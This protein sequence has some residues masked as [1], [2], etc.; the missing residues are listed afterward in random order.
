MLSLCELRSKDVIKIIKY[1][2]DHIKQNHSCVY[3]GSDFC[4]RKLMTISFD[5]VKRIIEYIHQ[6]DSKLFFVFPIVPERELSHFIESVHYLNGIEIDGIV[7]NDYGALYY[8]SNKYSHIPLAIGRLLIKNARDYSQNI[9]IQ[10]HRCPYEIVRI[11]NLYQIHQI[12]LD[13]DLKT[14]QLAEEKLLVHQ[15]TYITSAMRCEYKKTECYTS[16]TVNGECNFECQKQVI[17]IGDGHAYR[18]GNAV[19]CYN[20]NDIPIV[21]DYGI[22]FLIKQHQHEDNG[23]AKSSV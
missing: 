11:A 15:Y 12:H 10:E 9:N 7:V 4:Y 17:N 18:I 3:I 23:T 19:I 13:I 20:N 16:Y 21:L 8:I 22:D 1:L 2:I 14:E 6:A 5:D